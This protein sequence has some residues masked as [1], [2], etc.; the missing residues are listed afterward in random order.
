MTTQIDVDYVFASFQTSVLT[1]L[2]I[3]EFAEDGAQLIRGHSIDYAH[4]RNVKCVDKF[5]ADNAKDRRDPL[6]EVKRIADH[7]RNIRAPSS[8]NSF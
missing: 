1:F 2:S 8:T 5:T 6:F 4:T 7:S 3:D